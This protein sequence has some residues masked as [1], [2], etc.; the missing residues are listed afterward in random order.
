MIKDYN[1]NTIKT[2][3]MTKEIWKGFIIL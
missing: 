2:K 1:M 3:H